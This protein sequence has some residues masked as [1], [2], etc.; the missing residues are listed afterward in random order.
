MV[1]S[2]IKLKLLNLT[3]AGNI[4]GGIATVAFAYIVSKELCKKKKKTSEEYQS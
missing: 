2:F 4:V 1:N 3:I